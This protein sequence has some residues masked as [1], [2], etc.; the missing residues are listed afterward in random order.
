MIQLSESSFP[1]FL[2]WGKYK[3]QDEANPDKLL[4]EVT[5]TETFETDS[6]EHNDMQT[7]EPLCFGHRPVLLPA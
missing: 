7:E 2:K 4:I 3:S 5:D 6:E 1:P